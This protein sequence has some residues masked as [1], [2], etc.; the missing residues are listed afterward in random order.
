[1]LLQK[2]KYYINFVIDH[3]YTLHI[4]RSK[5]LL[6]QEVIEKLTIGIVT[7]FKKRWMKENI[8]EK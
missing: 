7:I 8:S 4:L 2:I 1:M 6:Y 3:P 5:Y